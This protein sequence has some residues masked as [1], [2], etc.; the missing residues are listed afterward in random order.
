[1]PSSFRARGPSGR[2]ALGAA[3]LALSLACSSGGGGG[4]GSSPIDVSPTALVFSAQRNGAV[5][6]SKTLD[7]MFAG[8][9]LVVGY[10]PGVTAPSW[11]SVVVVS[12]TS[13]SAVLSVRVNTTALASGMYQTTLR[14]VTG[15]QD[16]SA[17]F[18]KDVPVQYT[19]MDPAFALSGNLTTRVTEAATLASLDLPLV[20]D[21]KLDAASGATRHW[22][23]TS[24]V[25]WLSVIPASGDLAADAT[26]TV[27]LDPAKLWGKANATYPATITV[28][29]VEGDVVTASLPVSVTVALAPALTAPASVSFP[30]GVAAA[31]PDLTRTVTVTSN[32]GE[33]FASHGGWTASSS[34]GW[35]QVTPS[36]GAGGASLTLDLVPAALETLANGAQT[37]N[38]TLQATDARVVGATVKA[39]LALALP[40][41][42]HVAPYDT[43]FGRSPDVVLRGS[44]FGSAGTLPV[45]FGAQTVTGN[46]VSDS[47]LRVTAPTQDAA[48][49]VP[50]SIANSLGLERAKSELVVLPAP[51]YTAHTAVLTTSQR[52]I[53]LDPERQAVLLSGGGGEVRRFE[54]ASGA[55]NQ[56][57]FQAPK[58]TGGYVAA[59]GKTLLVTSGDTSSS[60]Q[61]FYEV[62][63]DTLAIVKQTGYPSYY[64][65]FDLAAPLN[66]GRTLIVDSEQWVESVWYPGLT[67]GPYIF[68]WNPTMLLTRDR[69]RL[70]IY[71]RDYRLV[72]FDAA[73]TAA[74]SQSVTQTLSGANQWTVSG[75]GNRVV[76]GKA[77]YDRSFNFLGNVGLQDDVGTP[78]VAVS[79]DG[80]TLYTLARN[81]DNTAWVFRRTDLGTMPY[82]ADATAL[83]FTIGAGETPVQMVVSEDGST[84]F[85]LTYGPS[86][87]AGTFRALPLP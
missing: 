43:W 84:L 10:P 30:V 22:Q 3:A 81:P 79:P 50:V 7:V 8:D 24:T 26:L 75:D 46:V 47:E 60:S 77:V 67:S 11:L 19:I 56:D 69:S 15:R 86:G 87:T 14:L 9:G 54:F 2:V 23:A 12:S 73:D 65:R 41:V 76:L 20:L 70:L 36:T 58:V 38:V 49:R 82:T 64:S 66:D 13:S 52:R 16:G 39:N 57:A 28:S 62:D 32:L 35:V 68:A 53:V 59:D 80:K 5:P 1:M 21:S 74:K 33:A 61:V 17:V 4:G 18:Y 72:T 45:L 71:D 6:A 40:D 51:G 25:D 55:W 27:R 63:P 42:A 83:S 78:S 37:A 44:G 48:G 85:L 34:A 29:T 31:Q